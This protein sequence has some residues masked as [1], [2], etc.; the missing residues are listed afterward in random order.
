MYRHDLLESIRSI[1]I[2][3]PDLLE[4]LKVQILEK[5]EVDNETEFSE[6]LR[7]FLWTLR[8][9]YKKNGKHFER[10]VKNEEAWLSKPLYDDLVLIVPSAKDKAGGENGNE[11]GDTGTGVKLTS[12][13]GRPV[14][15]WEDCSD[16]TKRRKVSVLTESNPTSLLAKAAAS[17]SKNSPGMRDLGAVIKQAIPDPAKARKSIEVNKEPIMMSEEEALALKIQCDLSDSQYQ[18]LRN[19][20]MKQNADIYPPLLRILSAKSACYP[21][22]VEVN[23]TSS[24]VSLQSMLDHTLRRILE[25][26]SEDLKSVGQ[27]VGKLYMKLGMDGASSQSVYNQ[28]FEETD[29][30]EGASNEESLF[31]TAVT[32]LKLGINNEEVWTNPKPSSPHFTRPLHIQYKKETREVI[33]EEEASVRDEINNLKTFSVDFLDLEI[34]GQIEYR[35]DV[36]MLDG[37]AVNAITDTKSSQACNVCSATPKEMN[38]LVKVRSKPAD[39]KAITLGLSTLH[40]LLRSFEFILH[41]GYKLENK[42]FQARTQ[43]EKDSVQN[44]KYVIQRRFREELSL[45]VDRPKQGFGNTNTGNTARRAFDNPESFSSITGVDI[46]VIRRLRIILRAVSSG[47]PLN[48]QAFK[49]FCLETSELIITLYGWYV[50]PPSVHKLLEH[51]YQVAQYLEL[52]IGSYSEEAQEACNK[53]VRNA[54]LSHTA[55]ISRKN[56]MENQL[57]YLLVR[58]DPKVSSISFKKH[59]S[60]KGVPL[61]QEVLNLLVEEE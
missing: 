31:M 54:R 52:P 25:M 21:S 60:V 41:L 1:G 51:G 7:I 30:Q 5:Y 33:V 50:M 28:K 38:D 55:K 48:I 43:E 13:G 35:V 17:R 61:E 44:R 47:Y 37:K 46:D 32:P 24:R 16:R 34:T 53:I 59:R 10:L 14:K 19:S 23:E 3:K 42:K 58:S 36:T 39:E 40:M 4:I 18:M 8:S 6:R 56:V 11:G 12:E 45:V 22:D 29:L 15:N 9:K 27:V 57:H 2:T 20:S 26:K 49:N